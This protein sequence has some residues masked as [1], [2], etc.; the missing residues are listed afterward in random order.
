MERGTLADVHRFIKIQD[1]VGKKSE[2][3]NNASKEYAALRRIIFV[4]FTNAE[5]LFITM[6][7]HFKKYYPRNHPVSFSLPAYQ[8]L[9]ILYSLGAR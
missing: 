7:G 3:L 9:E 8:R 2:R 5:K 6:E 4:S 1:W